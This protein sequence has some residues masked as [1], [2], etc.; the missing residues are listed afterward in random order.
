MGKNYPCSILNYKEMYK[1]ILIIFFSLLSY[2][3]FGQKQD[4]IWMGGYQIN[5]NGGANGYMFDFNK[6]P[7]TPEYANPP[8]GFLG[9]NAS[10]CDKDG[11]LLF[12][13]NGRA[14]INRHHQIMPNGDSINAGV[15]A[16]KFWKDPFD[17]YPGAQDVIILP[18]PGNEDGYYLFHK[19]NIYY[20]VVKDSFQLHYT[21]INMSLDNGKGDV[22]VKNKKYYEKQDP[23]YLYFTA[24]FHQNKKDWWI[25]QPIS[26][27]SIFLTYI[28]NETGIKRMSNQN[29][30][31][32]F[33]KFYSSASGMSKFSPDG[34]KY[35]LYNYR[36]QLH[37]YDFDRETGVLS[38]HKKIDVKPD[39]N[40]DHEGFNGIEWSPNSRFIYTSTVTRIHQIDMWASNPEE[41]VILID[42]FNGT[43]DPFSTIFNFMAQ[44]PDCRIYVTNRGGANSLGV[45]NKPDELG[46]DCDFVQNGI[47]LPYPNGGSFPNFPRFRVDEEDK[48]DPTIV[49]VFGDD[50][51]Y[52]RDLEVY[53]N[54]S[55]GLFIIKLPEIIVNANL[56]VTN[57]NGLV[58]YHKEINGEGME[59]IDIT[60]MPAGIYNIEVFP[61]EK[62]ERIFYGTQVI[63]I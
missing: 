33:T 55:T 26:E 41:A 54:P 51:Y 63:K 27:D 48:C 28:L 25:I 18:D 4:Y 16:D 2:L 6:S 19:P 49:S 30:H 62:T 52:R 9:N 14:V 13:T 59:E 47:K 5:L 37:V 56:V 29:T 31:Q 35:A 34:T 1:S 45:I 60:H 61:V 57:T 50:I 44:G 58:V 24:I 3:M 46:K 12:Y 42:T 21:Y 7:F 40:P 32:F 10:I 15:W 38:N 43:Q 22:V 23:M 39:I 20:P 11:N 17:G 8:L 53:P 36:D